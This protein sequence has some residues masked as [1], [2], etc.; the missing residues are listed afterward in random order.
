MYNLNDSFMK[1]NQLSFR[2]KAQT[3]L[4][5]AVGAVMLASCAQDG[6]DDDEMFV[7]DV[8]NEQLV[9]PSAEGITFKA[10][11]DN[12]RT[13][14]TWQMVK[15]AGGYYVTVYNMSDPQNPAVVDSL[16][17]RLID[18]VSLSI[19]R[20]ED[21]NYKLII[22]TAGN[23]KMNNAEATEATE[24]AFSSFTPTFA[25][26]PAGQDIAA[27]FEA[28]A[29][30]ESAITENVNYD[31]IAGE[32]YY[33][34]KDVDFGNKRVT[35]RSTSKANFAHIIYGTGAE[36]ESG[37]T[38]SIQTSAPITLKYLHID[39]KATK[40]AVLEFSKTPDENILG[41]GNYY[42]I[43]DPVVI[44]TC[45]IDNVCGS[46]IFDNKKQYCIANLLILNTVVHLTPGLNAATIS[47][48]STISLY[49]GF[50]NNL[51]IKE[52]TFWCTSYE[53]KDAGYFIRYSNGGRC[54]RAGF[55][56]NSISLLNNT[57]YN[58]VKNGKMG[59]YGG[60]KGRNTSEWYFKNNIFVDCSSKYTAN[61][62]LD[63]RAASSAK[64]CEFA[65]NTYMYDGEFESVDG[66]CANYDESGTA[67]E[68]DPGFADPV[69]GNFTISGAP[70][71]EKKTGDP[72]WIPAN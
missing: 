69:N 15:G 11:A 18:G 29:V 14:I 43:N 72:R 1:R 5:F 48:Q 39:A 40:E 45:K 55:T 50:A 17:N 38:A 21:T 61:R 47:E 8:R 42:I 64:I 12:S 24:V 16:D 51:T 22:K 63:G 28:N 56:S 35:L 57:F 52:S 53:G 66:K 54:D 19:T 33:L 7:S 31:L 68:V 60:I 41:K 59:N 34:S 6:Y 37:V 20:E 9:S 62:L 13:T 26:I 65:N 3:L 70:Q 10:N 44:N 58:I 23:D 30:P 36:G 71:L 32:T 49:G 25:T 27:W 67:I 2:R 46:F 4:S